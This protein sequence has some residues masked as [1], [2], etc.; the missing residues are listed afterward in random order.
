M[1]LQLTHFKLQLIVVHSLYWATEAV[2]RIEPL[3]CWQC[4]FW[5]DAIDIFNK[6]LMPTV[7]F[8]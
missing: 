6:L 7:H 2:I 5:K 8:N 4:R 1:S 3:Y